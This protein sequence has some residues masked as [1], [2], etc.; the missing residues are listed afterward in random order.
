MHTPTKETNDINTYGIH[1][2]KI[3]SKKRVFIPTEWR[4]LFKPGNWI[5]MLHTGDYLILVPS[6]LY[7]P[8]PDHIILNPQL[9]KIGRAHV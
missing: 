7:K 9:D 6:E 5:H 4:G 8:D 2:A 3:D 1:R